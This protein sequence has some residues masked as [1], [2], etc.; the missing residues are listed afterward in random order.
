M[1]INKKA[2]VQLYILLVEMTEQNLQK[3]RAAGAIVE[4]Q[5]DRQRIVQARVPVALTCPR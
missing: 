3:L 4:L 2:Q 1:R 5:D